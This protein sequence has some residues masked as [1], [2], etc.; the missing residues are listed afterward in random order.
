SA[1]ALGFMS[2]VSIWLGP[3]TSIRKMQLV[4]F[5][6]STAPKDF[7]AKKSGR[8]RPRKASEPACRKSR[9][10]KPSQKWQG[11]SASSLN[12]GAPLRKEFKT[13]CRACT[14]VQYRWAHFPQL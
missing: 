6:G 8:V 7:S 5:F 11:L 9:R 12:I 13:P 2:Q 4:S 1:G 3:P 14:S 10:V